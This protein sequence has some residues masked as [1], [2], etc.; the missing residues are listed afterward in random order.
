MHYQARKTEVQMPSSDAVGVSNVSRVLAAFFLLL[1]IGAA[2]AQP[3]YKYRGE[4][5]EWIYSDRPPADVEAVAEVRSM[6][7]ASTRSGVKV[8]TRVVDGELQLVAS[9][10]YY[11]PVELGIKIDSIKGTEYWSTGVLGF[12]H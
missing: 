11:A 3:L 10:D 1:L 9:N 2:V 12:F 8:S 6:S 7:P 4:D 5:G